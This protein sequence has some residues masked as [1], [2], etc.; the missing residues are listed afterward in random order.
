MSSKSTSSSS[1]LIS[2][3]ATNSFRGFRIL[4]K[5]VTSAKHGDRGR[6]L[7]GALSNRMANIRADCFMFAARRY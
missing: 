5:A 2:S 3:H 6:L 4:S 7:Q 1:E